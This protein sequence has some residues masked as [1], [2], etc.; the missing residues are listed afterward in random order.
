MTANTNKKEKRDT[1]KPGTTSNTKKEGG[2][3]GQ[4]NKAETAMLLEAKYGQKILNSHPGRGTGK[5]PHPISRTVIYTRIYPISP[6]LHKLAR[7][8]AALRSP[9]SCA[10]TQAHVTMPPERRGAEPFLLGRGK[11]YSRHKQLTYSKG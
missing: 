3:P 8:I 2:T 1:E 5:Y 4:Q 9:A 7:T 6:S 11:G 10:I